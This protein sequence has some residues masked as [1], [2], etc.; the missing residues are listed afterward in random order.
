MSTSAAHG[1]IPAANVDRIRAAREIL[2]QEADGLKLTANLLDESFSTAVELIVCCRG[3]VIVTGVGKAG[4]IGRKIT[5]T[6]SSTG[7]PA[8]FMHPTEAVHGDLGCLNPDDIILALSNSG[9]S[10]ELVN[11][12]GSLSERELPTIAITADRENSLAEHSDVTLVIGKHLEAGKSKLA[13]TTST[14]AMLAVG[15]ALALVAG[16]ARGF[17]RGDFASVHPAGSIGARLKYV[18]E[19]MRPI[20]EI[21]MASQELTVRDL[22]VE[23]ATPGRRSGAVLLV[24]SDS[25]LQGLFTDSDLARLLEQRRDDQFDRA[26]GEIMTPNPVTIGPDV[27]VGEAIDL[28]SARKLSELPVVDSD[29][30]PVGLLDITDLIGL[31]CRPSD[32]KPRLKIVDG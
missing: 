30:V 16:E 15:D 11:L 3:N 5:A 21:R 8:H 25:R 23:V 31:G 13:P 32:E 12:L 9:E 29:G 6:L 4:L 19:V 28:V 7:S 1:V 26:A 18:R 22:L 14:T 2:Q 20:N 17:N 27:R 24:D 10:A